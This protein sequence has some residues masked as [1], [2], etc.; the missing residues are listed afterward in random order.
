MLDNKGVVNG[1][2][3]LVDL[4]DLVVGDVVV[5]VEGSAIHFIKD[6]KIIGIVDL[7]N[8][9]IEDFDGFMLGFGKAMKP[10]RWRW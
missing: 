9:R 7:V 8:F 4:K 6:G 2:E 3:N 10:I 1:R 5:R